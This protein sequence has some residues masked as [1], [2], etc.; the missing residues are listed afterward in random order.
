MLYK[1]M[2]SLRLPFRLLVLS[3]SVLFA[4]DGMWENDLVLMCK[5]VR[6]RARDQELRPNVGRAAEHRVHQAR[7]SI[8]VFSRGAIQAGS[9]TQS[10]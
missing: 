2:A 9:Q 5:Y 7:L 3:G 6:L 4:R 8:Q 1:L 10:S